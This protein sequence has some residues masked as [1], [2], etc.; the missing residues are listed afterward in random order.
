MMLDM[1]MR[2]M[3]KTWRSAVDDTIEFVLGTHI[4]QTPC[5]TRVGAA[6]SAS[7]LYNLYL[8]AQYR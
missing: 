3:T 7:S 8:F 5:F 4:L 2:M 6:F 1:M